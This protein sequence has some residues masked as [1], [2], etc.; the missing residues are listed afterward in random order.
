MISVNDPVDRLASAFS[1]RFYGIR[2][3]GVDEDQVGITPT[4]Q[5]G[6]D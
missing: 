2:Q 5:T 3:H 6:E 1:D 4:L